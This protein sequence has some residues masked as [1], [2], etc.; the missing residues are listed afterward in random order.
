[1]GRRSLAACPVS[2]LDMGLPGTLLECY[3]RWGVFRIQVRRASSFAFK[4]RPHGEND[5][6]AGGFPEAGRVRWSGAAE[7]RE[8]RDAGTAA[9]V[10]RASVFS[11]EVPR[12]GRVIHENTLSFRSVERKPLPRAA[13]PW[14]NT[15]ARWQTVRRK[16][17]ELDSEE[18]ERFGRPG[19]SPASYQSGERGG[20]GDADPFSMVAAPNISQ[21]GA[22][23]ER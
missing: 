16:Y 1:M 17:R 4:V 19:A 3:A 20:Q 2:A 7:L 8:T 5:R 10:R 18:Q 9:P 21:E 6:T 23:V 14:K 22:F 12:I 15:Q 11:V 13:K